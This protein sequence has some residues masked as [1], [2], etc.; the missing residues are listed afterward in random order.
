MFNL[1]KNPNKIS[2]L[3]KTVTSKLQE[4]IAS[5]EITRNS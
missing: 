2:G 5:G 3:I 4:K 1:M